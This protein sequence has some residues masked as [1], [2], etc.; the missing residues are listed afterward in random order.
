MSE[1]KLTPEQAAQWIIDNRYAKSEYEK[2]TDFEMYH[3]AKEYIENLNQQTASLQE[4]LER[5]KKELNSKQPSNL[6]T[7]YNTLFKQ[8]STVNDNYRNLKSVADSMANA[9][10]VQIKLTE[11]LL[12]LLNCGLDNVE[13]KFHNESKQALES[14]NQLNK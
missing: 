3:A 11:Y 13:D 14:Y 9:L 10:E 8:V 4:E 6:Q 12:D 2:V 7:A 5:V 1:T